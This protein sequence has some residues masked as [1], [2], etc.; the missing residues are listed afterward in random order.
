ML[1]VISDFPVSQTS[2]AT[3]QLS[4]TKHDIHRSIDLWA[5]INE[6]CVEKWKTHKWI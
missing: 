3:F 4:K 6:K 1:V 2:L 5:K